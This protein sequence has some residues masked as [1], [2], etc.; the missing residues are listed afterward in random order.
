MPRKVWYQW[1]SA[2]REA[3]IFD[4]YD[5][6]GSGT[7]DFKEFVDGVM[8]SR[9]EHNMLKDTVDHFAFRS[10]EREQMERRVRQLQ[11]EQWST[12][13]VNVEKLLMEK[14]QEK[15]TG[16]PYAILRTFRKF[17]TT[18]GDNLIDFCEFKECM[19]KM[20]I[21]GVSEE[22]LRKL[23]NKYDADGSGA[24][25]LSE[26]ASGVMK[27]FASQN[28]VNMKKGNLEKMMVARKVAESRRQKAMSR[29]MSNTLRVDVE[30]VLLEKIE[31]KMEGGPGGLRRAFRKFDVGVDRD[32]FISL[33][34]F[35]AALQHF[36]LHELPE[37]DVK[38]LFDKYDTSGDGLLNFNEFVEGVMQSSQPLYYDFSDDEDE[39]ADSKG[40]EE[41][42]RAA[43]PTT[44]TIEAG[45]TP[46]KKR[47]HRVAPLSKE[48]IDR[49]SAREVVDAAYA[50]AVATVHTSPSGKAFPASWGAPPDIQTK[51]VRRL[52][53]GYGQGSRTLASW[54]RYNIDRDA[55]RKAHSGSHTAPNGKKF[56]QHW[57]APPSRQTRDLHR[58]PGGY[59]KGSRTLRSWIAYKMEADAAE[60]LSKASSK[61]PCKPSARR[62]PRDL[63]RMA[64][65]K[66]ARL[67]RERRER[68]RQ[69]REESRWKW[70][71]RSASSRM[72]GSP[73]ATL[74][75]SRARKE[76][77]LSPSI[78]SGPRV[79]SHSASADGL[80][81]SLKERSRPHS[82]ASHR[83]RWY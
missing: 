47:V 36:G 14:L 11:R 53:G 48:E 39:D 12:L 44:P 16:G 21:L 81:S 17:D 8:N 5:R 65:A 43:T 52:P 74:K 35:A 83:P 7:I 1:P 42:S 22:D 72:S 46:E 2:E 59:G 68:V 57:G 76:P 63:L 67:E 38:E 31:Q 40:P 49:V 73:T 9:S 54:I 78:Y 70:R 41:W 28:S 50:E 13:T 77:K 25:N 56:P 15:T 20:G 79:M 18:G 29:Y 75:R 45:D 69:R 27:S 60:K 6:D 33:P 61:N 37:R 82:A 32:G 80:S 62:S 34:E 26:F 19:R 71:P 3:E 23:F 64:K 24:I 55:A 58:L 51:D 10:K 66:Q 4:S 30:K